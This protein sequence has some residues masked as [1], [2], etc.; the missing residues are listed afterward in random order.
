MPNT[1]LKRTFTTDHGN[2]YKWTYSFWVKRCSLGSNQC[3]I[4]VRHSGDYT[5]QIKFT[6]NDQLEVH[7]YRT[8]YKLQKKTNRR[9]RDLNAWYHIVVSNDN[10]V[11]S[12][13]TK[14]YVNGV[15]E[16]SFATDNEYSQ[17]DKNSFNDDYPNYIGEKGTG[18]QF[19]G[20]MSHLYFIDGTALTAST[21]G[22]TDATTGIWKIKTDPTISSYGTNGFLILKD[23]NTITD[24]SPNSNDFAL[25]SGTLTAT[26]D[27][28]SNVFCTWNPLAVASYAPT[29][30]NGNTTITSGGNSWYEPMATLG[31]SSG[32]FYWEAKHLN[33]QYT[34]I[35][36]VDSKH[37]S[38]ASN[39]HAFTTGVT[40]YRND[41]G[42]EMIKDNVYTTNDYGTFNSD[43]DVMG[44]ACDMDNKTISIYKNGSAI[45]SNFALSTKIETAI[46]YASLY[47]A[48][49]LVEFN[50]GDGIFATSAVSSAGANASG[51]GIFEYDVP[52]GYTALSTKG[53]NL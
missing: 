20:L 14:I 21:F 44:I 22:E 11:S 32:K 50:F 40:I 49:N 7:D 35:G 1:T 4:G 6:T 46:P 25:D 12:P 24:Q 36:V 16:T 31:F 15:E 48:N 9:F 26:Q 30:S 19:D 47:Q 18:D 3:M 33:N 5:A 34:F 28:P 52:S 8:S 13:D 2:V 45:V 42:G 27:C 17:N 23:G 41:D 10:S 29:F 37:K 51:N 38:Y 39:S 53:L 43:S